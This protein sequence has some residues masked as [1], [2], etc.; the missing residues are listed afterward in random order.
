MIQLK[1]YFIA[2]L[3]VN[4]TLYSTNKSANT[5]Y[6]PKVSIEILNIITNGLALPNNTI[7]FNGVDDLD[8]EFDVK[9]SYTGSDINIYQGFSNGYFYEPND[10]NNE[11]AE[12]Y[13]N[14]VVPHFLFENLIKLTPNNA[15]YSHTYRQKLRLKRATAYNTGCSIV[16]TY[17]GEKA[18][19]TSNKLTYKLIGGTK[20]GNEPYKPATANINLRSISYSNGLPLINNTI[21]VPDY[22]RGEIGTTSIDLSFDYNCTYGS[23]LE[24]GYYPIAGI[25]IGD[26]TSTKVSLNQGK[27][28]I[29]TVT[30]GIITFNNI[31]IKSS[32]ITPDSYLKI[33]F[34]FQGIKI[35]PIY[36]TVKT[37]G[38][39][40]NNYIFDNQSISPGSK[41]APLTGTI[42]S[43]GMGESSKNTYITHYQWQ[44]RIGSNNWANI[45][46][47]TFQNYTPP[48]T[49]IQ[50]TSFRRIAISSDGQYN[51]SEY[52]TISTITPPINTICCNQEL[53]SA[54]NYQPT[55]FIGNTLNNSIS[56]QWQIKEEESQ[57]QSSAPNI[58]TNI[59]NAVNSNC[60]YIFPERRGELGHR[61]SEGGGKF[62]RLA[63]QNNAIISISNVINIITKRATS[64]TGSIGRRSARLVSNDENETIPTSKNQESLY[65]NL[66]T[67]D[68]QNIENNSLAIDSNLSLYPNPITNNFYIQNINKFKNPEKIKLFDVS[69]NEIRID[70]TI[71]SDNLIEIN[72]YS[73]L[74]GIYIVHIN[75]DTLVTKKLIKN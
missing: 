45:N 44:Q 53:T 49:F 50:T 52:I 65:S 61:N 72:T 24:L 73:T 32:D 12:Y 26:K 70:K 39:I 11:P 55:P 71:H 59:P 57:V 46:G 3:L 7:S 28:I 69:G 60:S 10:F 25:Q 27:G 36:A 38:L 22:E 74:P 43:T 20:T 67:D 62:R 17:R 16:F 5:N 56:Y 21:I 9:V 64:G 54:T 66:A 58:W 42:S 35:N 13:N 15:K 18:K 34:N 75:E 29:P 30:N 4:S 33:G 31:K 48:N 8:I 14:G 63:I 68:S 40:Q 23:K 47:A 41:S 1:N 6:D 2:L 37:S 51:I 19:T